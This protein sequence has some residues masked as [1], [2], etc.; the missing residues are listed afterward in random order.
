MSATECGNPG[1]DC[2]DPGGAEAGTAGSG[3]GGGAQGRAGPEGQGT[4]PRQAQGQAPSPTPSPTSTIA[5]PP[6]L[7]ARKQGSAAVPTEE[8]P[9]VEEARGELKGLSASLPASKAAKGRGETKVSQCETKLASLREGGDA[10]N[11]A[12]TVA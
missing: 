6:L 10:G 11:A 4:P 8:D 3:Q 9:E 2:A 12:R 5:T 1:A 7:V